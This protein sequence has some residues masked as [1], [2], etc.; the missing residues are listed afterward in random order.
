[1]P[2]VEMEYEREMDRMYLHH[3]TSITRVLKK[4]AIDNMKVSPVPCTT[5]LFKRLKAYT[6][7][8]TG[9]EV[10]EIDEYHPPHRTY[11]GHYVQNHRIWL[12]GGYLTPADSFHCLLSS[13]KAKLVPAITILQSPADENESVNGYL[14]P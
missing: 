13:S 14:V 6:Y 8:N 12:T 3:H 7:T 5:G 11:L 1:M 10:Q 9:S 2:G 4:Y